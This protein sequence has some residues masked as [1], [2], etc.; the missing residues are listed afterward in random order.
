MFTSIV[1]EHLKSAIGEE[2]QKAEEKWCVINVQIGFIR[3][4]INISYDLSENKFMIQ[5]LR[6]NETS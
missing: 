3:P 5:T 2:A 4:L 6:N 1:K